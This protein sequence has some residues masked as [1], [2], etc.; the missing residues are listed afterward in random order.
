MAV[1]GQDLPGLRKQTTSARRRNVALAQF[2]GNVKTEAARAVAAIQRLLR[3][4]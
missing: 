1:T 3:V 4:R 2:W